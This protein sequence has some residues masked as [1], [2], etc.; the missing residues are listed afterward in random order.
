ME[1]NKK[2]ATLIIFL[3]V[4]SSIGFGIAFTF[5]LKSHHIIPFFRNITLFFWIYL[6]FITLFMIGIFYFL[7]AHL[8][9][10]IKRREER[11]ELINRLYRTLS[12][13]NRLVIVADNKRELLHDA[14]RV[15]VEVGEFE[16][17]W[18]ALV[19]NDNMKE[20]TCEGIGY[21]DEITK[22]LVS[23]VQSREKGFFDELRRGEIILFESIDE[24]TS[25]SWLGGI[26]RFGFKSCACI[27]III[28]NELVA[29]MGI[30]SKK[31][32]LINDPEEMRLLKEI[33]SD[34]S[35]AFNMI[36]K[37]EFEKLL[38][39]A[40]EQ[41]NEV[42]MITDKE[43]RILYVN[44]AIE[45]VSGFK[46][47]DVLNKKSNLVELENV[48]DEEREI[49]RKKIEKKEPFSWITVDRKKFG[50]VYQ[51]EQII[52]PIKDKAGNVTNYVIT[53]R[54][55]TSEEHLREKLREVLYMDPVTGLPNRLF[56]EEK[57]HT[58]VENARKKNEQIALFYLDVWGFSEIN[59]TYGFD[60]GDKVLTLVG[61]RLK[62]VIGDLHAV[63]RLGGDEFGILIESLR[64]LDDVRLWLD[65]ITEAFREPIKLGG[66][67]NHLDINIGISVFPDGINSV[68]LI[69]QADAALKNAKEE[70]P[71]AYKFFTEEITIRMQ[72]KIFM[73]NRLKEATR[74]KNFMLYYQPIIDLESGYI[75]GFEA[76]MRW[77][78]SKLGWIPPDEFIPEMQ[79][80]GLIVEVGNWVLDKSWIDLREFLK[81]KED[82]RVS[83]NLSP[84]QLRTEVFFDNI[85]TRLKKSDL[86]PEHFTFE[87]TESDIM[88]NIEKINEF[89]KILREM[90]VQI[91]IDDFGTGYSSLAY[92]KRLPID[93]IKIDKSFVMDIPGDREDLLIVKAITTMAHEL[94]FEI[95]AEGVETVEQ[96]RFLKELGV[97][98]GQGYYFSKPVPRD[99]ALELF[100]KNQKTPF[101]V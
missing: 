84:V 61:E 21:T 15:F 87:I 47:Q 8:M 70:G 29:F 82:I 81:I 25:A 93:Q 72:R 86:T 50:G 96:V 83:I 73:G 35:F 13:I 78:D 46:V 14:C 43:G 34:L 20:V 42:I 5:I 80:L 17:A 98:Y 63:A 56:L 41:T 76:L 69:S 89:L 45:G 9:K 7:L 54:D 67:E 101:E 58:A 4:I 52:T 39:K 65:K 19:E 49:L 32:L 27:P 85:I 38:L 91:D 2:Q 36:T 18:G 97:E 74:N 59:S 31:A 12:R 44:P 88:T 100:I 57:L 11:I 77:R 22:M 95:I 26:L 60:I 40:F 3:L 64:S 75:L 79:T 30:Y 66:Y 10:Q 62:S 71:G 24:G 23:I 51:L 55:I 33:Q 6:T 99:E 53:G 92:L 37:L 48:P 94:G 28:G 90:G 16:L 1:L 68:E